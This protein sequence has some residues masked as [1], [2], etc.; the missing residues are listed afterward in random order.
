MERAPKLAGPSQPVAQPSVPTALPRT[1]PPPPAVEPAPPPPVAGRQIAVPA[2]LIHLGSETGS[3]LRNPAH[4]AD[5]VAVQLTA[6]EIDALP[7]PNDP[8]EAAARAA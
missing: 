2:G 1:N 6:F 5:H 3:A 8:H 7:Y 4:E